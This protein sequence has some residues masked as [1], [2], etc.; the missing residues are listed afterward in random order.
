MK[1][2]T[3]FD[4]IV[5]GSGITGGLAA[6]ELTER[7]LKVLMLERGR[8]I[9][10]RK[11]YIHEMTPPWEI[12]GQGLRDKEGYARDYPIQSK[13]YAF[14]EHTRHYWNNDRE[15]PYQQVEGKPFNWHRASV[16][17][18]KSILWGRQS[19]RWNELDFE[20]NRKD[21]HGSDWPVR[22]GDIKDWYSHVE[23]IV[24]VSG[25][26]DGLS[27]L[28]D[29]EFLPPMAFNAADEMFKEKVEAA[30]PDRKV[31]MGRTANVSV[32]HDGRGPCQYR[33]ICH[34]GCSFGA[35]FS[36]LS[37]TLPA[38]KKTGRLTIRAD[39]V[40][41]GLDYDPQT[42]R[43]SAVRVIDAKT[44]EKLRFSARVVFLCASTV[45]S[46]QILM[47]SRSER[48]PN[49][50]GNDS[51]ILGRYLMDHFSVMTAGI[52]GGLK[53]VNPWGRRPTGLY[54]PRFRNVAQGMEDPGFLRGYGFQVVTMRNGWALTSLMKSGFGK[55]YKDVLLQPGPWMVVM[56]G[57]GECLPYHHNRVELDF[58][59]LDRFGI[60]Q[61]KFDVSWGENERKMMADMRSQSQAMMKSIGVLGIMS[62]E[63]IGAVPGSAIHEMGG[64]RMGNDPA[65][66]VVNAHNQVHG[67]PNLF[68]TDGA[69][70]ASTSCVNPSMTFMA[71]TAR[72]A[73]YAV[74]QIKQGKI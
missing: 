26:R 52:L 4:A 7:G 40:V 13:V 15:N 59:H 28:P 61:V 31:I 71:F 33:S 19:Y 47:N 29:G 48:Y 44:K 36:T 37:S 56:G 72:A 57:F 1:T 25:N 32:T 38:A 14:D 73:D 27:V 16:L 39:S 54:V 69:A 30:F 63:G 34:R 10:H 24:G 51:G 42:R 66:S 74:S 5:I 53:D 50:L 55:S 21:G 2:T 49:G 11:D 8:Y 12:P 22:Y 45:G 60:P 68:V 46:L 65:Q 35:Y 20:A 18:G 67:I 64:A 17:G 6:K 58:N 23:R 70:M 62:P 41:E 3:Q 9:E 43:I